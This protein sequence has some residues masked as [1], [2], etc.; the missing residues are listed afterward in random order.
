[1]IVNLNGR[2]SL[3][4]I[5][6]N[7]EENLFFLETWRKKMLLNLILRMNFFENSLEFG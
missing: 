1:M 5:S 4:S 6:P 7:G 3:T 2:V